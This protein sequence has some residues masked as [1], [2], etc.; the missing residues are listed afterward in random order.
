[1]IAA[2]WFLTGLLVTALVIG[3]RL[4]RAEKRKDKAMGTPHL[5]E[6]IRKLVS[7][8]PA[9]GPTANRPANRPATLPASEWQEM[10]DLPLRQGDRFADGRQLSYDFQRMAGVEVLQDQTARLVLDCDAT[11]RF[12]F[13]G[14]DGSRRVSQT[15]VDSYGLLGVGLLAAL[16]IP[17]CVGVTKVVV[18]AREGECVRVDF[19]SHLGNSRSR[20]AGK[21]LVGVLESVFGADEPAVVEG[22]S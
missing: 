11:A 2:S 1:M 14:P 16:G 20:E 17:E 10:D 6:L 9:E 13:D 15:G 5:E 3:W 8:L 12:E 18:Q 22:E 4:D 7:S 19:Q 21:R